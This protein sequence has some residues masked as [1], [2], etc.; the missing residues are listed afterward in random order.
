MKQKW[1]WITI[2][3][4]LLGGIAWAA[5][6]AFKRKDGEDTT[7]GGGI[8]GNLFG[9]GGNSG[10]APVTLDENKL[11]KKGSNGAEVKALQA[12]LNK[13]QTAN[14]LVVDGAF[15]NLTEAKLYSVTGGYR[16]ITL[17]EARK[18][19]TAAGIS[20]TGNLWSQ[21]YGNS[22]TSTTNTNTTDSGGFWGWFN[23]YMA[24]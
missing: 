10:T 6:P 16:Q 20:T 22:S 4:V 19:A 13:V 18:L 8:L 17:A 5:A 12:L 15:G 7:G 24:Y 3:L 11:L 9:G 23:R 2:G 1:V 14:P 21:L